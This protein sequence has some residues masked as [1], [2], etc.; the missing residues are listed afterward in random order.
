MRGSCDEDLTESA[1]GFEGLGSDHLPQL[2]GI[3]FVG[4]D[5]TVRKHVLGGGP[6][7]FVNVP[8]VFDHCDKCRRGWHANICD[9]D[10][11]FVALPE[12]FL[13]DHWNL[14]FDCL[15]VG[16]EKCRHLRRTP[17]RR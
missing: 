2:G 17:Q 8:A 16:S 7:V 10:L 13:P 9:V 1:I 4:A 3:L 11:D 6:I 5:R 15:N 14:P 12:K